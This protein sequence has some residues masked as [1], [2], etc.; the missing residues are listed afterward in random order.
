MKTI[1]T[2]IALALFICLSGQNYLTKGQVYDFNVGD[3]FQSKISFNLNSFVKYYTKTILNKTI[4]ITGDS[5]DYIIKK[6][7]YIPI[8]CP[9]CQ[10]NLITTFGTL[11]VSQLSDSI[12]VGIV[13][14]T[15][16]LV[17]LK[18]TSYIDFCNK[19]VR[20]VYQYATIF[21]GVGILNG[22]YYVEACGGPYSFY[23]TTA[24][25]GLPYTESEDLIYYKKGS[26]S[27][28]VF[29]SYLGINSQAL[30]SVIFSL[31]PNPSNDKLKIEAST[32]FNEYSIFSTNGQIVQSGKLNNN[33][34]DI[35]ALPNGIYNLQVFDT[36]SNRVSKIFMKK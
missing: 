33:E 26:D 36:K 19:K 1:F 27:C 12:V 24:G 34:I 23:T 10:A 28:G 6:E 2:T 17:F 32:L 7:E 11:K 9:T 22:S 25:N 29:V 18:D 5:I 20:N 8:Q 14:P 15:N 16:P 13:A 3:V 31:F 35:K 30:N 4:S 21:M